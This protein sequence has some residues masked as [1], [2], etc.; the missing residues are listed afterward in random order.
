[1][2]GRLLNTST[3]SEKL[4]ADLQFESGKRYIFP[5]LIVQHREKIPNT[6]K[7]LRNL[8][9][10]YANSPHW[11]SRSALC[12]LPKFVLIKPYEVLI[13][14]TRVGCATWVCSFEFK[15]LRVI[16]VL[17]AQIAAWGTNC[18][19][20][21]RINVFPQIF[22]HAHTCRSLSISGHYQCRVINVSVKM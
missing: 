5:V 13:C 3:E 10:Y 7:L 1:M 4:F 21:W 19:H 14:G 17:S 9:H 20:C 2:H 12:R 16:K 6:H 11:V 15:I 18:L 22:S 8:I